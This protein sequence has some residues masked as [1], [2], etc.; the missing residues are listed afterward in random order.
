MRYVETLEGRTRL[1]V[2]EASLGAEAP[3]TSPVFFNPAA[4]L[5]R[6]VSVAVAAATGGR[7]FCDALAGVGSRGVRVANEVNEVEAAT[8]VDF[9]REAIG[10]ARRAARLNRVLGR[11]RFVAGE[12]GSFLLSRFGSR[13]KFD[14]VDVDPFGSPI[15]HVQ[16]AVS[17]VSRGGVVSFTATDTAALCGVYPAA[18]RR[19]YGAEPLNNHFHHETGVRILMNAVSRV[20]ARL[21][22]GVMPVLAHSSRH[23]IRVFVRVEPGA[24]RADAAL[25][26]EGYVAWC[27][28]CGH[29]SEAGE[30]KS[31]CQNCGKWLKHAGPLWLGN[32]T[33]EG[34]LRAASVAADRR[35]L[36]EASALLRELDGVDSFPPWAFSLEGISSTLKVPTVPRDLVV[37][38]LEEKGYVCGHQP[39]EKTG[40]KTD[41]PY[42]DVL[43]AAREAG[44]TSQAGVLKAAEAGSLALGRSQ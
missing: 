17:A 36:L 30:P 39:F 16:A 1:I 29:V 3:P 34:L 43:E 14:G 44:R 33:D 41:A 37:A 5:N 23:Y 18:A 4:A 32:L 12:S 9:N 38:F 35:G 15:R 21:E 6:D 22:V 20:A 11:C 26:K 25:G 13:E 10:L 7:T 42:G 2:P 40:I 27:R 24:S 8:L 31:Q 28:A 19:R